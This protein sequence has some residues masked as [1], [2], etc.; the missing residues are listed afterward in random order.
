MSTDVVVTYCFKNGV[1]NTNH[2]LLLHSEHAAEVDDIVH[3]YFCKYWDSYTTTKSKGKHYSFKSGDFGIEIKNTYLVEVEHEI[4][5]LKRVLETK[6][7][8]VL[9]VRYGDVQ[10]VQ[11]QPLSVEAAVDAAITEMDWWELEDHSKRILHQDGNVICLFRQAAIKGRFVPTL[12]GKVVLDTPS[13]PVGANLI[14][15]RLMVE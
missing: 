6:E 5:L 2:H 12:D 1:I 3:A 13:N 11:Y 14:D 8:H 7:V 15:Y 10:N 9:Y 4:E